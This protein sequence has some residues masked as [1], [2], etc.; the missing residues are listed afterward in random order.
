MVG[1]LLGEKI[2]KYVVSFLQAC[3]TSF[4]TIQPSW[5]S[6]VMTTHPPA[7]HCYP[8]AILGGTSFSLLLKPTS[9]LPPNLCNHVFFLP[10]LPPAAFLC[11]CFVFCPSYFG[12]S[13]YSF[14]QQNHIFFTSMRLNELDFTSYACKPHIHTHIHYCSLTSCS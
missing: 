7:N 9:L 13:F 3:L 4:S 14:T 11:F 12:F 2:H 8:L 6:V 5:L 1:I 10:Q